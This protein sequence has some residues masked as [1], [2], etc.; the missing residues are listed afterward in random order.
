[1]NSTDESIARRPIAARESTWAP[2]LAR[3]AISVRLTP[4]QV[5]L[6]SV[7]VSMIA[8]VLLGGSSHV[9]SNAL[10]AILLIGAAIAIQLRL[11]CNLIDGLMAVE[12]NMR[13]P[14]GA[15]YNDF[16]DRISDAITI[17]AAGYAA[18]AWPWALEFGWLAALLA[19]M[20]A[21]VRVLGA[22][23][24]PRVGHDFRGPMAKQ[25]RMAIITIACVLSIA[26]PWLEWPIGVLLFAS[27][28]IIAIGCC[29]TIVRR[30][31]GILAKLEMSS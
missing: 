31:R 19:V 6:L 5:S 11:L 26:E 9:E 16:P 18:R 3:L 4:N 27:L 24:E 13:S 8:A 2:V 7:V 23:V 28:M 14:S 12:G 10:R 30:S 15:I 17:V 21:Y 29:I 20:T 25:Q 1:M 22:S